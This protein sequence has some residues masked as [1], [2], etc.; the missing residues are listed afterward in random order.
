[1]NRKLL[2]GLLVLSIAASGAVTFTSCKD[3]DF[4]DD[5]LKGMLDNQDLQDQLD[6]LKSQ[7]DSATSVSMIQTWNPV[8]GT[9]DLPVGLNSTVLSTYI[10]DPVEGNFTFPTEAAD[11]LVGFLSTDDNYAIAS[12]IASLSPQGAV[13]ITSG[14]FSDPDQ[15]AGNMGNLY[16]SIN[17]SN[18]D[19][20][21]SKRIQLVSTSGNVLLDAYAGDLTV[22][23]LTNDLYFG[24]TR[25]NSVEVGT[26]QI[27]ANATKA[28]YENMLFSFADKGALENALT[29][30]LKNRSLSDLATLGDAVYKN[31]EKIS[32]NML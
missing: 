13:A 19:F 9:L 22:S 24:V 18:I 14:L 17:P 20:A 4:R 10:M 30:I 16:V 28:N 27:Q 11:H 5:V 21:G 12:S 31:I 32:R 23:D 15:N 3:E 8:F 1:M 2:N 25:A 29:D 7:K 26:Y 6:A